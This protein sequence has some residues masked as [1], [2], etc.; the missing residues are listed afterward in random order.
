MGWWGAEIMG[1]DPS[2]D[3]LNVIASGLGAPFDIDLELEDTKEDEIFKGY[4]FK[5]EDIKKYLPRL[6]KDMEEF[7][8]AYFKSIQYQVLGMVL[9]FYGYPMTKKLKS[10]IISQAKKDEWYKEKDPERIESINNFIEMIEGYKG[11]RWD[12]E[13][14]L[15]FTR[16]GSQAKH[17]IQED[18]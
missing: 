6:L 9:M 12:Q 3:A 16:I 18:L 2:L 10:K 7:S 11:G 14:D 1:G 15:K 4:S 17:F 13:V 5:K 8:D